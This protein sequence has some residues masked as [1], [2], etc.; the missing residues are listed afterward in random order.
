VHVM[1]S[2]K[3]MLGEWL[4]YYLSEQGYLV[5]Y[6]MEDFCEICAGLVGCEPL[7]RLALKDLSVASLRSFEHV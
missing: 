1:E 7:F 5:E 4:K 6:D 2:R 3:N